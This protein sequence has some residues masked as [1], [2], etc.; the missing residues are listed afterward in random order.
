YWLADAFERMRVGDWVK[1]GGLLRADGSVLAYWAYHSTADE[2]DY[3]DARYASGVV[4]AFEG[5]LDTWSA[6]EPAGSIRVNGITYSVNPDET[7]FEQP[8]GGLQATNP[9]DDEY[10]DIDPIA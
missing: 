6:G 1:T 10:L 2:E 5:S 7:T 9:I 8:H 4:E 3:F